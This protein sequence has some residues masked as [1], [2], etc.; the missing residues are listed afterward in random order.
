MNELSKE[1]RVQI[2]QHLVEGTS[3]RATARLVDVYKETVADLGYA[4]G[5][6][7]LSIHD[8]RV[9]CV[10]VNYIECDEIWGFVGKKEKCKSDSDPDD[11]GDAYTMFAIDPES[12]FIPSYLTGKRELEYATEFMRDLR[13]R[14][15]GKPQISVDGWPHWIEA[16]RRAFGHDGCHLGLTVKEYQPPT[17]LGCPRSRVKASARVVVYGKPEQ[18][19][20][21]T[22]IAERANLTTRMHQRRLTRL[23]N[24][25]SKRFD[26]LR[27]SLGLYFM[28]YNFVRVH[29]TIGT[30]P[31]VKAGMASEPWTLE[32][33]VSMAL[34][35][36]GYY[37]QFLR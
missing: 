32:Y 15:H 26:C 21:S 16:V 11:F 27:A 5:V 28:Y 25:F 34:H 9:S 31:A 22:A 30:T 2:I 13:A 8:R 36:A 1:T 24:A 35:E 4:L 17:V 23:T 20:I 19:L 29:E 12:K 18:E 10:S 6:A 33:L 7:C 37:E 3:I 14:V